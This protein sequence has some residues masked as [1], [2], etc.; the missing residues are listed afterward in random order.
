MIICDDSGKRHLQF[1]CDT[2]VYAY[3]SQ[4]F[5]A[6]AALQD[7]GNGHKPL[8]VPFMINACLSLELFLKSI[9]ATRSW[10]PADPPDEKTGLIPDAPSPQIDVA[11][12]RHELSLLYAQLPDKYREEIKKI[13][14]EQKVDGDIQELLKPY[15]RVF[16]EWRYGYERSLGTLASHPL[17]PILSAVKLFCDRYRGAVPLHDES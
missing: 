12:K 8:F 14:A 13:A 7:P 15:D 10:Y 3:A 16:V 2:E 6:A 5:Q 4:F 17:V 11:L 1:I 9:C